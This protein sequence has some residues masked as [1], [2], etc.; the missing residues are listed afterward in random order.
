MSGPQIVSPEGL[1]DAPY[2]YATIAPDARLV[3]TAGACPLDAAGRVVAPDDFE[4][5]ARQALDNLFATLAAAGSG[6]ELVL[7]TTVYVASSDRSELVRVWNL[8]AEGFASSRPPSTLLGVSMLGYPE[9]LVEIEAIA[10][11]TSR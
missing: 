7:K 9:Q 2:E 8:V 6:P 4:A 3:F 11:S 5:Q 10:V 1:A